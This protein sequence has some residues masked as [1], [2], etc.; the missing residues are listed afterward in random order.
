VHRLLPKLH[1]VQTARVRYSESLIRVTIPRKGRTYRRQQIFRPE[2]AQ[3]NIRRPLFRLAHALQRRAR[4]TRPNAQLW[5]RLPSGRECMRVSLAGAGC[6]AKPTHSLALAP[7]ARF[8][9]PS[10]R[11][12]PSHGGLSKRGVATRP[13]SLRPD[14]DEGLIALCRSRISASVGKSGGKRTK[15]IS[16]EAVCLT[17]GARRISGVR[18]G[19]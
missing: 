17:A 3:R 2:D 13:T 15:T 12:P 8:T 6:L 9:D 7:P 14:V 4:G 19:A 11:W 10:L 5:R 16:S 18:H 1:S